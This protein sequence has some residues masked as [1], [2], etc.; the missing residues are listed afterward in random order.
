MT[1]Y[2]QVRLA[3]N[4]LGE[5]RDF[6]DAPPDVSRK[7][8]AWKPLVVTDPAFDPATQVRTGPV[9]TVGK[10]A[11]TRVWTVRAKSAGE[12]DADKGAA[13]DAI[14][15]LQ[16]KI[17]LNHENRIRALEAKQAVTAAQFRTALKAML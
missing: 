13:V 1:M 16:L 14:D 10:E 4:A 2:V 17:A 5:E 3:D 15:A 7:G 9:E 12:L 8:I 11:V 6:I